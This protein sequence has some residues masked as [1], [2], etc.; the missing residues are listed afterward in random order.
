MGHLQGHIIRQKNEIWAQGTL[1][2]LGLA[3]VQ[4]SL[5]TRQLVKEM[6]EI[7][8]NARSGER[9]LWSQETYQVLKPSEIS[10]HQQKFQIIQGKILNTA[11]LQNQ[12]ILN[13]GKDR[14]RSFRA[15][16]SPEARRLFIQEDLFPLEWQGQEVRMRGIPDKGEPLRLE[17]DHPGQ[18]ELLKPSKTAAKKELDDA[19]PRP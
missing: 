5:A 17:L 6:L 10:P 12:I 9:G 4:V 1:L 18:I 2:S 8:Q 19:L 15:V 13:F 3:R 11:T 14:R 16:I 7:E